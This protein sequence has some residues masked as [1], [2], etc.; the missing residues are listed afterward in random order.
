M[1]NFEVV[2]EA[3]A[4]ADYADYKNIEGFGHP[5]DEES[6]NLVEHLGDIE[7]VGKLVDD[8]QKPGFKLYT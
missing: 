4:I 8:G 3:R 1:P 2:I 5:E 6:D 7:L